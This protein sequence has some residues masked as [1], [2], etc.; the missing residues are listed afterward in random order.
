MYSM[1]VT[2]DGSKSQDF[3]QKARLFDSKQTK[4]AM[5]EIQ[6]QIDI[7]RSQEEHHLRTKMAME[8]ENA[9]KHNEYRPNLGESRNYH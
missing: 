2:N 1:P 9:I 5:A 7:A 8:Q 4:Q 3:I 6:Q